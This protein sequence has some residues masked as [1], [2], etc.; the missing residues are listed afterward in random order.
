MPKQGEALSGWPQKV[1]SDIGNVNQTVQL[2]LQALA[3]AGE[4]LA[5]A[6]KQWDVA[7][8]AMDE[9]QGNHENYV[10]EIR[11]EAFT[12]AREED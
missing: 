4:V 6:K 1:A 10:S 5:A 9:C 3:T 8:D 7:V 12:K 2:A 11:S